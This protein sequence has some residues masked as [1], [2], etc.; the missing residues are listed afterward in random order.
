MPF[1]C[2]AI[3]KAG[4]QHHRLGDFLDPVAGLLIFLGTYPR[5][6]L[7]FGDSSGR[8]PRFDHLKE[9]SALAIAPG[10]LGPAHTFLREGAIICR[11]RHLRVVVMSLFV[12][13][14]N[15]CHDGNKLKDKLTYGPLAALIASTANRHPHYP[16]D[17]SP[18]DRSHPRVARNEVGAHIVGVDGEAL[19]ESRERCICQSQDHGH[20]PR[21]CPYS[22]TEGDKLCKRCHDLSKKPQE[23]EAEVCD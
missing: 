10:G 19:M 2:H 23:G 5:F 7:S 1:W 3:G 6:P 15:L 17:I 11:F 18:Q 20:P 14:K 12:F 22:A 9:N 21:E 16:Q 13:R 8:K 4:P